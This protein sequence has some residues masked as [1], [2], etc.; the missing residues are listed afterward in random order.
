MRVWQ[1][2]DLFSLYICDTQLRSWLVQA[3]AEQNVIRKTANEIMKTGNELMKTGL[4]DAVAQ[5]TY[6]SPGFYN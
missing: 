1:Q 2:A 4:V 5:P 6:S 3:G